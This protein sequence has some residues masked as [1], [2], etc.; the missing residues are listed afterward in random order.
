MYLICLVILY[1]EILNLKII[2][3]SYLIFKTCRGALWRSGRASDSLAAPYCVLGQ[4]IFTTQTA[5][6]SNAQKVVAP[7]DLSENY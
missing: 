5:G 4:G 6:L 1:V 2:F 7:F 3:I